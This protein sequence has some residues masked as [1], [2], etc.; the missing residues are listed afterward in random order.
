MN[1][2]EFFFFFF[3]NHNNNNKIAVEVAQLKNMLAEF[4]PQKPN[5]KMP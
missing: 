1:S 4:D 2:S 5:F 3:L